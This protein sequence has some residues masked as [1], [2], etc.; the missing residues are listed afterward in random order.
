[1]ASKYFLKC[2]TSLATK[3]LQLK[4]GHTDQNGENRENTK[5][6]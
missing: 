3:K 5:C 2:S 4:P 1:M 6:W